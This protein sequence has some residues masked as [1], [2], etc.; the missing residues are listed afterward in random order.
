MKSIDYRADKLDR[1]YGT[2]YLDQLCKR[3]VLK[4]LNKLTLGCLKVVDGTEVYRFGNFEKNDNYSATIHVL[5]P[6]IYRKVLLGGTI[7]VGESYIAKHWTTPDLVAMIRLF[8]ANQEHLQDMETWL[9]KARSKLSG[10]AHWLMPNTLFKA[11]SNIL[12]HYDLSN[13]FFATFLDPSMMY[14]SGIFLDN[15]DSMHRASINKLKIACDKLELSEHDHLLE[16]GTGWGGL[17]IY[18]AEHYGCRVTTTTISDEQY[19]YAKKRVKQMGLDDRVTV[20][21]QDYRAL[22]GTYDKLISIEMIEAVGHKHYKQY[23][24]TCS[25]LL[26]NDGLMLIQAITTSDQRFPVQKNEVDFI[27]KHIFPGGCLPSHQA[28]LNNT[29]KFTN[30]NLIDVR[31]MTEDY[32]RTLKAWRETFF[33]KLDAVKALGFNASFIRLWEF[34]LSYCEGG[35]SER[36]IGTSQLLFA[37]PR[38]QDPSQA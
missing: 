3:I 36:V 12:A 16:I 11:K 30:L 8:V 9:S 19:D 25:R 26:K 5:H 35:F 2:N 14:S 32:A 15:Q 7:G 6:S 33:S 31:D 4:S 34:Y 20:L 1:E 37:K 24:K 22:T 21:N 13:D 18:A 38:Y 10:L 27:R 23:F 28:I 29:G 17:A